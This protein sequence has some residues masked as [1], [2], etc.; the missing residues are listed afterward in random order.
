MVHYTFDTNVQMKNSHS[1][2]VT[3]IIFSLC[4]VVVGGG[5]G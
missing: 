1:C 3:S 5:M 4:V 2:K